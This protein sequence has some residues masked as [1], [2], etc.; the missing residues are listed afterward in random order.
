MSYILGDGAND[1]MSCF[2]C[3]HGLKDWEDSDEP[4]IEHAR[5]S[6]NCTFL[7]LNKGKNFVYKACGVESNIIK[8]NLEVIQILTQ[9]L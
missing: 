2:Y 1:H 7:L 4:W 5:W 6:E 9:L 8:S 3:S